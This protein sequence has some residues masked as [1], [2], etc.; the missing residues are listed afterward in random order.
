MMEEN[1]DIFVAGGDALV[2]LALPMRKKNSTTF[3]WDHPF[4]T[5]VSQNQFFNSP[6]PCKHMYKF[7]VTVSTVG[8]VPKNSFKHNQTNT[9]CIEQY[10]ANANFYK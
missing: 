3:V 1:S 2:Y 8:F 10:D 9:I 6:L 4:R 5:Y 7:R